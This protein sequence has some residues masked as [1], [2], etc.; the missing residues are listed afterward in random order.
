MFFLIAY[1]ISWTAWIALFALHFSPFTGAGRGLYVI[2]VIAPHAAALVITAVEDGRAGLRAFYHRVLRRVPFRWAIVAICVPP[3]IYLLRDVIFAGFGLPHGAFFHRLPRTLTALVFGQLVVVAGEEPG[4]RGF[5]LPRLIARFGPIGG[6]LILGIA[7]AVWHLP[8]FA[9]A[10]TPQYGTGFL[11]FA[12]MLLAW[13]MVITLVVL[14]AQ[15][16]VIPAML[17]HT[18]VNI[19]AFVMWEPDAQLLALGPWIVAAVIAGWRIRMR[20]EL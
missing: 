8:L 4:W 19:C 6:T 15:G 10:G 12:L 14:R 9:I 13:S 1:A 11:P 3:V 18:S 7:W 5:A 20:A 16:S 2:A 17:F